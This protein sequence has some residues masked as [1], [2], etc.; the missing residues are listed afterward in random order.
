MIE[1]IIFLIISAALVAS[2][3]ILLR[4]TNCKIWTVQL[5]LQRRFPLLHPSLCKFAYYLTLLYLVAPFICIMRLCLRVGIDGFDLDPLECVFAGLY[6]M[7]IYINFLL[8]LYLPSVK[9]RITLTGIIMGAFIIVLSVTLEVLASC[10]MITFSSV[11]HSA[12]YLSLN[13]VLLIYLDHAKAPGTID[14]K[15]FCI[16]FANYLSRTLARRPESQPVPQVRIL[17]PSI[18]TPPRKSVEDSVSGDL[19]DQMPSI[20]DECPDKNVQAAA[21]LAPPHAEPAS[22]V[23]DIPPIDF[24]ALTVPPK[25]CISASHGGDSTMPPRPVIDAGNNKPE[26]EKEVPLV[27][28]VARESVEPRSI[29]VPIVDPKTDLR[30]LLEEVSVP[31]KW[32][33]RLKRLAFLLYAFTFIIYAVNY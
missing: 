26:E 21:D 13:Y 24:G 17:E 23:L 10:F 32:A 25:E 18:P 27:V 4:R 31:S 19:I 6:L 8:A 15:D 22:H 28:K 33:A 2:N 5:W 1:E 16:G 3:I 20:P 14:S 30:N 29:V 9:W 12:L 7:C 11:A